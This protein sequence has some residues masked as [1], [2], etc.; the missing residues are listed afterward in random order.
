MYVRIDASI[1]K[2]GCMHVRIV[3]KMFLPICDSIDVLATCDPSLC[4]WRY[5]ICDTLTTLSHPTD[6]INPPAIARPLR[7]PQPLSRDLLGELLVTGLLLV[8]N[9]LLTIDG[10]RWAL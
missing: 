5:P 7:T 1:M 10:F 4:L 9:D 6:S 8:S 3:A 2:H